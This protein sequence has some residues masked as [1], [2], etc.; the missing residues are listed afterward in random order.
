MKIKVAFPSNYL[1]SED[2]PEPVLLTVARCEMQNVGQGANIEEKPVVY[3]HERTK[4]IIL[5]VTNFTTISDVLGE[6]SDTWAGG[7]I[8]AFK[9]QTEYKGDQVDCIR[10][11]GPVGAGASASDEAAPSTTA[12]PSTPSDPVPPFEEEPPF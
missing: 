6:D 4:P 11:R 9:T 2:F 1:S 3:F 7:K 12:P 8:V 10:F 5:N